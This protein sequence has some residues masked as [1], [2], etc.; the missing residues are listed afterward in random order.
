MK[1]LLRLD[2][3]EL[4]MRTATDSDITHTRIAARAVLTDDKGRVALMH[5]STIAVYKL[6]GGGVDEGE[7]IL[8]GLHREVREETGYEIAHEREVVV[9][10]EYR[11]YCGMHQVSHAYL[12][13]V[14]K[15][16]GTALTENEAKGGMELAWANDIDEA[17]RLIQS[18]ATT[19]EEDNVEGLKM[20]KLRDVA[21]LRAAQELS[22]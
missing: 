16:V 18:G 5:I 20:M 19:D 9:V 4:G 2:Q 8:E 13:N 17:V 11:Y 15:F 22:E 14:T 21:I 12:A 6:P 3:Y 7:D 1:E 10:D